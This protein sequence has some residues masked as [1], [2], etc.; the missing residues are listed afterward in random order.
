MSGDTALDLSCK[1]GKSSVQA[2]KQLTLKPR[3]ASSLMYTGFQTPTGRN[4]C[5]W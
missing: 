5:G 3:S 2:C 4:N 1:D